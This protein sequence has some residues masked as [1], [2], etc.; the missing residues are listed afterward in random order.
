MALSRPMRISHR[1][2]HLTGDRSGGWGH[3]FRALALK[4]AGVEIADLTGEHDVRTYPAM[5]HLGRGLRFAGLGASARRRR[6]M[7]AWR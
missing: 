4:A 7:S 3:Y 6:A 5:G 2:A 1:I